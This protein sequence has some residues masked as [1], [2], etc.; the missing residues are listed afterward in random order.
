ELDFPFADVTLEPWAIE[1]S[2]TR[3]AV[4]GYVSTW[5]ALRHARDGEGGDP[6]VEFERALRVAWPGD[7]ARPVRW[8]LIVRAGRKG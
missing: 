8:P 5:S 2:L 1:A 4:V 7:E 3:D 6:L